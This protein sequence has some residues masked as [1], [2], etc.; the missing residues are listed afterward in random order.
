MPK[1]SE[2]NENSDPYKLPALKAF[3]HPKSCHWG[4]PKLV[5]L[6]VEFVSKFGT[7]QGTAQRLKG[8]QRACLLIFQ[9]CKRLGRALN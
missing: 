4:P 2:I 3:C 1:K 6:Y 5:L 8:A 9:F 7:L